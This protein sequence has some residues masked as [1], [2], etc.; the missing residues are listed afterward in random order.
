MIRLGFAVDLLGDSLSHPERMAQ[1][2]RMRLGCAGQTLDRGP[3]GLLL[4]RDCVP[5]PLKSLESDQGLEL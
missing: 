4:S 1:I 3:G 5:V 2:P